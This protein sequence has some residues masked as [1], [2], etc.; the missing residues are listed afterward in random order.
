[1]K[2]DDEEL[3]FLEYRNFVNDCIKQ[4]QAEMAF[5]NI[6]SEEDLF[7][8]INRVSEFVDAVEAFT[9]FNNSAPYE[10]NEFVT[11]EL[12]AKHDSDLGAIAIAV[13]NQ[14]VSNDVYSEISQTEGYRFLTEGKRTK[15]IKWKIDNE[16]RPITLREMWK[17]RASLYDHLRSHQLVNYK[18]KT[19]AIYKRDEDTTTGEVSFTF[20]LEHSDDALIWKSK[21]VFSEPQVR[22]NSVENYEEQ[23]TEILL[24]YGCP[25]EELWLVEVQ[26]ID[27]FNEYYSQGHELAEEIYE[28][29]QFPFVIYHHESDSIN[30][31][32]GFGD[33]QEFDQACKVV[34]EYLKK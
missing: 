21:R 25:S 2:M 8:H 27:Q 12:F 10:W 26:T 28:V 34:A 15:K 4:I 11:P 13:T 32:A 17:A 24:H 3:K 18:G 9:F 1:M 19:L 31:H 20:L 14:V 29:S 33:E 16:N 30:I 6:K 7:Q 22:E 5:S 23:K